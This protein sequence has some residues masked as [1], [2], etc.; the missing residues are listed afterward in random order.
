[1]LGGGPHRLGVRA[2]ATYNLDEGEHGALLTKAAAPMVRWNGSF[3]HCRCAAP[4]TMLSSAHHYSPRSIALA[5]I[6][7]APHIISMPLLE[8]KRMWGE[9]HNALKR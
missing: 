3:Q 1:M 4:M 6:D 9:R 5:L 8:E 2:A 7:V